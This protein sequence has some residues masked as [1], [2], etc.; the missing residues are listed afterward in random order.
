[1]CIRDRDKDLLNLNEKEESPNDIESIY[2]KDEDNIL[3]SKSRKELDDAVYSFS[4]NSAKE[5]ADN[6]IEERGALKEDNADSAKNNKL[7]K[8]AN[9][10]IITKDNIETVLKNDI[11]RSKKSNIRS[12][13]DARIVKED[14]EKV[15]EEGSVERS[16]VERINEDNAC[17]L[18]TSPSPRD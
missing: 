7:L 1:M 16:K 11:P 17:L 5:I 6:T 3:S 4:K 8:D 2:N 9:T 13:S 15:I 14:C 10:G 12:K 18:Y